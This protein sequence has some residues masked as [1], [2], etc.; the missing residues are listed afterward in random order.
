MTCTNSFEPCWELYFTSLKNRASAVG[1]GR[2]ATRSRPNHH[3]VERRVS[4]LSGVITWRHDVCVDSCAAF[5]GPYANLKECPRYGLPRYDPAKLAKS[6]GRTKVPQKSFATFPVGLRLQ[7]RWKSPEMTR[8]THYRRDKTAGTLRNNGQDADLVWDDILS[9]SDDLRLAED[10]E[11][12][13]NR[14]CPDALCRLTLLDPFLFRL[15]SLY[16]L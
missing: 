16:S 13:G 8:K 10:G 6:N 1:R 3:Q 4:S 15:F 11:I 9:G 5:T 7:S 14:R 12:K 2:V